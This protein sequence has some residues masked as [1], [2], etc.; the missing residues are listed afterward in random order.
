MNKPELLQ[1]FSAQWNFEHN[2]IGPVFDDLSAH[3]H[4]EGLTF[5][6][7]L[8]INEGAGCNSLSRHTLERTLAH[9][10]FCHPLLRRTS[11]SKSRPCVV[12]QIVWI[13][14]S[15]IDDED[16]TLIA[17]RHRDNNRF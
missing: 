6:R 1:Q 13:A 14:A 16:R 3:K 12:S 10:T 7:V 15:Y 4:A 17:G 11:V 8:S 9:R 2:T 5:E